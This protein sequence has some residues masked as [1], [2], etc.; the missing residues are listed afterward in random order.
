VSIGGTDAS[1]DPR[2][3]FG[4]IGADVVLPRVANTTVVVETTNVE[5]ASVVTVRATPR[6]NGNFSQ[7]TATVTEVV[8]ADP[9]VVRWT[10]NVPVNDGYSAI[11]VKVVRP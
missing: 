5:E 9:L 3:E 8:S 2:A 10:A 11:Q 6:S 4:S 7:A 1:A